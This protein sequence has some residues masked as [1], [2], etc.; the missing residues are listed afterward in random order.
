MKS[1]E[2]DCTHKA[3]RL[4][5]RALHGRG[6]KGHPNACRVNPDNLNAA[7]RDGLVRDN[8]DVAIRPASNGK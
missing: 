3:N 8:P 7:G 2:Q 5:L 1:S 6:G 4:S